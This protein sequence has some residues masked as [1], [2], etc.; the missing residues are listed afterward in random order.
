MGFTG[1]KVRKEM[2]EEA[3]E[4]NALNLRDLGSSTRVSHSR[5]GR[6]SAYHFPAV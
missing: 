5:F 4:Q 2:K 3:V 1:R 6:L